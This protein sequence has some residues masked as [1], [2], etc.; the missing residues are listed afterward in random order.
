MNLRRRNEYDATD[1]IYSNV[2]AHGTGVTLA[3]L[4]TGCTL[5]LLDGYGCKTGDSVDFLQCMQQRNIARGV[6]SRLIANNAPLYRN[7]AITKYL[8]DMFISLWQCEAK[9]QHQNY[10]EN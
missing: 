1:M 9:Y 2:P 8:N 7:S 10:I 4:F 5:K 6:P 3:H